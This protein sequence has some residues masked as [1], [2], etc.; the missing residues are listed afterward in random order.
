MENQK[1]GIEDDEMLT[2]CAEKY[3]DT[4]IDDVHITEHSSKKLD[5][6]V[7]AAKKFAALRNARN[8][9]VW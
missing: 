1:N 3:K 7:R 2:I 9:R 4:R 5:R 6:K 8:Y